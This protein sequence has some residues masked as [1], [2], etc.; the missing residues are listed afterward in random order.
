MIE[1]TDSD[2]ELQMI[3][4]S[5]CD[6]DFKYRIAEQPGGQNIMRCYTCG[7]CSGI[8]PVQ[9]V[10][11]RYNPRRIIRMALLGME[12]E[13]LKSDFIWLC[14]GC[15]SC[16]ERCPQDVR[17]TDLMV[18]IRNIAS[19][20]GYVHSSLKAGVDL[21]VKHGRMLEVSD[22][23]NKVRTKFE[24]DPIV[25]EAEETAKILERTGVTELA[26]GKKEGGDA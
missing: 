9:E 14:S 18:A 13:V 12:D 2:Q 17:I 16:H 5:E 19:Q 23:E 3:D 22:F 21:L 25:E 7:T 10:D 4:T 24:L 11:E 20:E 26:K 1:M 8:C 6:P 15:Y